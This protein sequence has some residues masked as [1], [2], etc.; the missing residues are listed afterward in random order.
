MRIIRKPRTEDFLRQMERANRD[1][2]KGVGRIIE[3][4]QRRRKPEDD[5]P[6]P[7]FRDDEER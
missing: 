1:L 7:R 6:P 2:F 3:Q 4:Q 5:E